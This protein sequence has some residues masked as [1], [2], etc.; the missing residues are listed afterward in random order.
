MFWVVGGVI[1]SGRKSQ[2]RVAIVVALVACCI[3]LVFWEWR[4]RFGS[5]FQRV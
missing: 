1:A 2:I 4:L 5:L 3:P